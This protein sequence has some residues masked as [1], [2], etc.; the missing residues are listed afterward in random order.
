MVPSSLPTRPHSRSS[1]ETCAIPLFDGC[2]L[3]QDLEP[4]SSEHASY[5]AVLAFFFQTCAP[6]VDLQH[7]VIGSGRNPMACVFSKTMHSSEWMAGRRGRNV[8]SCQGPSPSGDPRALGPT[9]SAALPTDPPEPPTPRSRDLRAPCH[10]TSG[11][12]GR[13]RLELLKRKGGAAFARRNE[14][15]LCDERMFG[16]KRE[17]DRSCLVLR[18]ID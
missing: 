2:V 1:A 6:V 18:V 9:L 8:A 5:I 13:K 16:W 10:P 17:S 7:W 14:S 15:C 4:W 12:P 3:T 11:G